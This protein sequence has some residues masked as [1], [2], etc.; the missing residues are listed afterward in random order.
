V[1]DMKTH[2]PLQGVEV[3]DCGP[4]LSFATTDNGY[5]KFT[6]FRQPRDSLLSKYVSLAADGTFTHQPNSTKLAYGGM[7]NLRIGIHFICHYF[8][9][10]MATIGTRYSFLRRQFDAKEGNSVPETLVI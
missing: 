7:L 9:A 6:Y 1:R 5:L 3:G 10:K 4:K 8:I 2:K